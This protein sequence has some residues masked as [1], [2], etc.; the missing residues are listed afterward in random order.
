MTRNTQVGVRGIRTPA[1]ANLETW[2]NSEWKGG[3]QID[4]LGDLETL[5][6]QTQNSTYEITVICG[7]DGDVLV[8]GG[9]FFPEKTPAHLSGASMGGSFLKLRGI[10]PGFR[11]EILHE[12]RCI[13]TSPVL[14]IAIKL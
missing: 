9:Q 4:C 14:G 3:F 8:R 12:G 5:L 1:A 13:V 6:V 11:M 7:K 2:S 10:Y